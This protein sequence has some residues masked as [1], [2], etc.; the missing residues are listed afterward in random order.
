MEASAGM[1]PNKALDPDGILPKTIICLIKAHGEKTLNIPANQ[2]L[3][4]NQ[5]GAKLILIPNP[6][7]PADDLSYGPVS[8]LIIWER[9][10]KH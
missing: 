5:K 9:Y 10:T 1:K 8:S 2:E 7:I 6:E 3:P 4:D